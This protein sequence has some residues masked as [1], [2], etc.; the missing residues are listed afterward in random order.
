MAEAPS[1]G[2]R[3]FA[4]DVLEDWDPRALNIS[5]P[6]GLSP[7]L[8]VRRG[9]HVFVFKTVVHP[10]MDLG[11]TH[12]APGASHQRGWVPLRILDKGAPVAP[13]PLPIELPAATQIFTQNAS[14]ADQEQPANV[15]Q[16]TL[17]DL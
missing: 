16:D 17:Q 6:K 12:R 3:G 8:R 2:I 13:L 1:G 11:Y 10:T 4:C 9:D 15:L 5:L 14:N 7:A